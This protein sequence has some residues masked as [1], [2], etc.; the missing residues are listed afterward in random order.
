MSRKIIQMLFLFLSLFIIVG[1]GKQ[2][3]RTDKLRDLKCTVLAPEELPKELQ[4]IVEEKKADSFKLTFTDADGLYICVGYGRQPTGGYSISVTEL[5]ETE[6]SIYVHTN[7]MGPS[8]GEA[9]EENPSYPY[10]VIKLEKLDK[11]VVF[12]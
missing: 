7:L 6:N 9:K 2:Q 11:A 4:A 3:D 10:V 1:C 12:G 8:P 5:F